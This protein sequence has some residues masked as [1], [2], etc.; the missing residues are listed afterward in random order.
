MADTKISAE[1]SAAPLSGTELTEIVQSG[2]NRK[3]IT[4]AIANLASNIIV[5]V[6]AIGGQSNAEGIG[7]SGQSITVPANAVFQAILG[8]ISA[9]NDPIGVGIPGGNAVTGSAWPSFGATYYAL[10]GRKICFVPAAAGGTWQNGPAAL[11]SG[12]TSV[13]HWDTGGTLA[14]RLITYFN[15]AITAL[16]AL[17]YV[18]RVMGILWCQGENDAAGIQNGWETQADWV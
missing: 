6:Y 3:T 15:Q 14:P 7:V 12:G 4:Q 5:D 2:N 8:T 9:A 17:G 13:S 1:L 16:Q 10:T 18:P 11:T